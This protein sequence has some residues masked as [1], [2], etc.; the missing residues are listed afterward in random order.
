[1]KRE[2][3]IAV[4]LGLT[5]C[6]GGET[7]PEKQASISFI[8]NATV[9]DWEAPDDKAV[10]IHHRDGRWYR[11]DLLGPCTGLPFASVI[12]FRN[13]RGTSRFSRFSDV[14]VE[15]RSCKVTSVI[16]VPAP[17]SVTA[18][19]RRRRDVQREA[20]DSTTGKK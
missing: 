9:Q 4:L 11:A 14:I 13:E 7:L 5:A 10:F 18:E 12:G 17:A 15:G 8:S 20:E 2:A 16:E 19:G 6:A 3:L 1:M